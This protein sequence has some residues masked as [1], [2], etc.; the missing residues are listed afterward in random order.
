M[1][2]FLAYWLSQ[3]VLSSGLEEGL[4]PVGPAVPRLFVRSTERV[5]NVVQSMW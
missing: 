4:N 5:N 3:Y 2:A 1:E